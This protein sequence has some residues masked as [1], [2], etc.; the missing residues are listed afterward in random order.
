MQTQ[1]SREGAS[2]EFVYR[3]DE[4]AFGINKRLDYAA[5][6][7]PHQTIARALPETEG[8]TVGGVIRVRNGKLYTDELSGHFYLQW[9]NKIR[10]QFQEF[11]RQNGFE[12]IHDA[13]W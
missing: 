7:S 2:Y 6:G 5:G 8:P 3:P 4:G 13:V 12:V 10:Q 11:M 9:T 1:L